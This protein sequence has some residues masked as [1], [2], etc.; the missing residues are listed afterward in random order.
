M[1]NRIM[2][3]AIRTVSAV[4][5]ALLAVGADTRAAPPTTTLTI[6]DL[7]CPACAKKLA[8]KLVALPGVEKAEPDVEAKSVKV[9][10]KAGGALSPKALWEESAK[11]G[12]EPS[13]LVGPDG[14]FTTKPTK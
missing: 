13:K 11:A 9:T 4:A 12:F 14:T 6:P 2:R 5:L 1:R 8:A 3:T 7:D 10:H